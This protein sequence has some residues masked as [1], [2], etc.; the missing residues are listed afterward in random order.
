MGEISRLFPDYT[1]PQ[2]FYTEIAKR[3]SMPDI[4]YMDLWPLGPAQ[5]VVTGADAAAA[6]IATRGSFP[7]HNVVGNFLAMLF[8]PNVIAGT[9]GPLWKALHHI[10]GPSFASPAIKSSL[11]QIGRHTMVYREH[12]KEWSLGTEPVSMA[13]GTAKLVFDVI[14]D[15]VLGLA[16]NT[17]ES[18]SPLLMHLETLID[19][20][21]MKIRS[22]N[23]ITQFKAKLGMRYNRIQMD[24]IIEAEL[25]RRFKVFVS[26]KQRPLPIRAQS[27]LDRLLLHHIETM[28]KRDQDMELEADFLQLA[29]AK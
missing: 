16:S 5:M 7:I 14:S 29:L 18:E 21:W 15:F 20:G 2:Y 22:W 26:E 10:T 12:L 24:K 1:H 17:Q 13:D 23:P 6:V 8:G 28:D 27:V 9:N 25:K 4:W 11:G 19:Y 3:Y